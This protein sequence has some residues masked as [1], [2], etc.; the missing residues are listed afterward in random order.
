M[1]QDIIEILKLISEKKENLKLYGNTYFLNNNT[2]LSYPREDGDNR[3]PLFCDGYTV[4]AYSSGY[5]HAREGGFYSLSYR[6]D[7]EDPDVDFFA[8]FENE[9]GNFE[10]FSLLGI[11]CDNFGSKLKRYSVFSPYA[12]YYFT[13]Y[14]DFIFC[15]RLFLSAERNLYFSVFAENRSGDDKKVLLSTYIDPFIRFERLKDYDQ[16]WFEQA[17][18]LESSSNN[19]KNHITFERIME[20]SAIIQGTMNPQ[21]FQY[22]TTTSRDDYVGGKNRSLSNNTSLAKGSF[23]KNAQN[24]FG[25]HNCV[26]GD[27]RVVN[28]GKKK[29]SRTDIRFKVLSGKVSQKELDY[30]IDSNIIDNE[31]FEKKKQLNKSGEIC[32]IKFG[33][34][35]DKSIKS[36]V[37]N[38]F[39]EFLKLQ[40]QFNSFGKYYAWSEYLGIRDVWQQLEPT[41]IWKT[42]EFEERAIELL[43]VTQTNGRSV[44]QYGPKVMNFPQGFDLRE[45]IDQGTWIISTLCSYLKFSGNTD[46]FKRICGYYEYPEGK[47][48]IV[49]E[50][51][52][53]SK[54]SDSVAE[55]IIR[56]MDYLLIK[57]DSVTGCIRILQGD[58]NDPLGNLGK[59]DN[60]LE[61]YGTG[62]SVMAS[63]Q[64]YMNLKETVEILSRVDK[65]KYQEIINRYL[66][67]REK[68]EKDIIREAVAFDSNGNPR[69]IHGWGN[70]KKFTVGSFRD[71]DGKNRTSLTVQAYWIISEIIKKTP[72]LKKAILEALIRLDSKYGFLTFDIPFDESFS[73]ISG[74]TSCVVGTLEN[75]TPY[76]HA[77][78]FAVHSL[79]KIGES[80]LAFEQLKK[81]IPITHKKGSHSPYVMPNS[82]MINS[83]FL[84][85]GE[86][87]NDWMTGSAAVVLKTV[88][89]DICGYLPDYDGIMISPTA[90]LFFNDFSFS[91]KTDRYILNV[92]CENPSGEIKEFFVNNK[93]MKASIDESTSQKYIYIPY[94][95]KFEVIEVLIK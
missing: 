75:A 68:L 2:V 27:I 18:I 91:I 90:H 70:D 47:H 22:F 33:E 12:C 65:E 8:G 63:L 24:C 11:P 26:F 48:Y 49:T 38:C 69:I 35:K 94:P 23:E 10:Y 3:F 84:I 39:V 79:F 9:D 55:H 86:S 89:S 31:L 76:V 67:E 41:L 40:T 61:D 43:S 88:L 15:V 6:Q 29:E 83:D 58:W 92:K 14:N 37:L 64:V 46:F 77:S 32:K 25:T 54:E 73:D 5:I 66:C 80:R 52:Y 62:V 56:I 72:E 7:G 34:C 60:P 28:V 30:K 57:R 53:P 4:W 16:R 50:G 85:D 13:E 78:A 74:I 71:G 19:L 81:I 51:C 21:A 82:Y 93:E 36:D 45:Y 1:T 95:D 59:S 17:H 44:R 20:N 42:K 87:V